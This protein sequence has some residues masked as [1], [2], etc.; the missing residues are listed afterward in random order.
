MCLFLC[1]QNL[2]NK[3]IGY[4]M[5]NCQVMCLHPQRSHTVIPRPRALPLLAAKTS[6]RDG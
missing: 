3:K 6:W 5:N 2:M 1:L 4:A